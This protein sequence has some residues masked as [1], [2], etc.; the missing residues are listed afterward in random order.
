MAEKAKATALRIAGLIAVLALALALPSTAAAQGAPPGA[1]TPG[2]M[3]EPASGAAASDAPSVNQGPRI[4]ANK[5]GVCHLGEF[6]LYNSLDL[7]GSLA[8]FTGPEPDY[9]QHFFVSAGA[10]Q[11]TTVAQNSRSFINGNPYAYA[12]GCTAE[13]YGG[14]CGVAYPYGVGGYGYYYGNLA[15]EFDLNL[16]SHY[17]GGA[18]GA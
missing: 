10:G 6:C 17:F 7:Q 4:L 18:G 5:D 14:V 1:G 8:D 2:T 15:P 16:V 11:N 9:K 12:Y 3:G 13:F